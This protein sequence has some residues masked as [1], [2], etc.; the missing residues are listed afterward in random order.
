MTR[1]PKTLVDG[2]TTLER[3]MDS[4]RDASLIAQNQFAFGYNTT[5]RGGYIKHRPGWI[6]CSLQFLG[7][8]GSTDST[9]KSR[10]EDEKFQGAEYYKSASGPEKL[11]CSIGGRQFAITPDHKYG[12]RNLVQE[13]TPALSITT[14]TLSI[15]TVPAVGDDVQVHIASISPSFIEEGASI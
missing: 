15:F 11:V 13:I 8:D 4:G 9:L 7:T 1:E 12:L 14:T 2:F 5:V 10:F 3:G 6:K